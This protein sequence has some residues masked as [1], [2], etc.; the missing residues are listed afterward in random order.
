MMVVTPAKKHFG[1]SD[2]IVTDSDL[3]CDGLQDCSVMF[4]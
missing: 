3:N 4:E 1:H 2:S